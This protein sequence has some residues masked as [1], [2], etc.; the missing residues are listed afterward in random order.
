M[1]VGL[2]IECVITVL[3]QTIFICIIH[4]EWLEEQYLSDNSILNLDY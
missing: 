1:N 3:Y 2:I 4:Y